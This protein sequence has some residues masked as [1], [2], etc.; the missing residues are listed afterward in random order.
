MSL[1]RQIQQQ[2]KAEAGDQTALKSNEGSASR[3]PSAFK[4]EGNSSAL[5]RLASYEERPRLSALRE[6]PSEDVETRTPLSRSRLDVSEKALGAPSLRGSNAL[7]RRSQLGQENSGE[8]EAIQN[9]T[10]LRPR[11]T[12]SRSRLAQ[13]PA[14]FS[15]GEG[16]S[17]ESGQEKSYEEGRQFSRL[18]LASAPTSRL[19]TAPVSQLPSQNV[20]EPPD[21]SRLTSQLS[22]GTSLRSLSGQQERLRPRQIGLLRPGSQDA[23]SL[24]G[25]ET[26]RS[27]FLSVLQP[28]VAESVRRGVASALTPEEFQKLAVEAKDN[29]IEVTQAIISSLQGNLQK[30]GTEKDRLTQQ[31]TS[32]GSQQK[33]AESTVSRI[34]NLKDL[35]NSSFSDDHNA[36]VYIAT[37]M[38]KLFRG[39]NFQPGYKVVFGDDGFA[40]GT[41]RDSAVDRLESR[42]DKYYV[43]YREITGVKSGDC[44]DSASNCV[45][46]TTSRGDNYFSFQIDRAANEFLELCSRIQELAANSTQGQLGTV[47][48]EIQRRLAENAK[49]IASIEAEIKKRNLVLELQSVYEQIDVFSSELAKNIVKQV[50]DTK[51]Q[52]SSFKSSESFYKTFTDEEIV[53]IILDDKK[54]SLMGDTLTNVLQGIVESINSVSPSQTPITIK[55]LYAAIIDSLKREYPYPKQKF[56]EALQQKLRQI[57]EADDI[58]NQR[59]EEAESDSKDDDPPPIP[60]G[61]AAALTGRSPA[62]A[63]T[64][65]A[66]VAPQLRVEAPRP[67]AEALQPQPSATAPPQQSYFGWLGRLVGLG[68]NRKRTRRYK[69]LNALTKKR[70][71]KYKK[72]YTANNAKVKRRSHRKMK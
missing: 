3:L 22:T 61:A 35:W 54:R 64:E 48:T 27:N 40:W 41:K 62:V 10:A 7:L 34:K 20:Q 67:P 44:P 49:L 23:S 4:I 69:K 52:Q 1:R 46:V 18:R 38:S 63:L 50:E 33:Q 53:G 11:L 26:Q 32:Q 51:N 5:G 42:E 24:S 70:I 13:A 9:P 21:A 8:D 66:A 31:L 60:Q 19:A 57:R 47:I 2:R 71:Q 16:V 36:S 59:G 37:G 29:N 56:D 14:S 65:Q 58:S 6:P 17:S 68:G 45:T 15:S 55:N 72:K 25:P 12:F 39:K 28:T 43:G 30:L